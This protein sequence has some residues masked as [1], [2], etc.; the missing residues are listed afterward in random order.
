[1]KLLTEAL[2]NRRRGFVLKHSGKPQRGNV[3]IVS[4]LCGLSIPRSR[5]SIAMA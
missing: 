2:L 3:P 5:G 1:M 4:M